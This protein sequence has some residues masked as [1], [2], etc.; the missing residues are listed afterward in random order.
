MHL[1]VATDSRVDVEL[2]PGQV[3]EVIQ[4]SGEQ[5]DIDLVTDTLGGTMT[6]KLINELLCRGETSK[7]CWNCP[8]FSERR[9]G[10]ST[11]PPPTG[12]ASK[13]TTTSWMAR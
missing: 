6:N 1:E 8:E 2:K 10:V 3:S 13:I 11:P 9:A 4:V 12:I 7:T 5:P